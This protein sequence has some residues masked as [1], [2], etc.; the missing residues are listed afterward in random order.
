[1]ERHLISGHGTVYATTTIRVPG[2]E[3]QGEEPYEVCVVD[4]GED[5]SVRVTARLT[6]SE[7]PTLGDEV[8]FV[9]QQ[10]GVFHFETNG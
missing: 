4:V 6:D 3:F 9:E 7:K 10:D 8:K 1:M 5:E 2:A